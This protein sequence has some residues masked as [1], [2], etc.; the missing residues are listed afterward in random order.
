MIERI[1]VPQQPYRRSQRILNKDLKTN[2]ELKSRIFELNLALYFIT[3]CKVNAHFNAANFEYL[4]REYSQFYCL[5]L[6]SFS[7]STLVSNI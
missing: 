2:I 6:T 7:L 1:H 4:T 3:S 5:F